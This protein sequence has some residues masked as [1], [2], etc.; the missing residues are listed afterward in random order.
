ML[1]TRSISNLK[2]SKVAAFEALEVLGKITENCDALGKVES[3]EIKLLNPTD[4]GFG[5]QV[6]YSQGDMC[7]DVKESEDITSI[8]EDN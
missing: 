3:Q 4:P 8:A 1:I 2:Y 5:I 6:T 7:F